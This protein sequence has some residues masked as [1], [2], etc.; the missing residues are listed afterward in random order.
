MRIEPRVACS[1]YYCLWSSQFDRS[2][3]VPPP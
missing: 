2:A 1:N 3:V